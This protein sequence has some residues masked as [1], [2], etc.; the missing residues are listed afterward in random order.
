MRALPNLP[1]FAALRTFEVVGRLQSFRKASEELCISQSAVS[2]HIKTLEDGVRVKLFSRHPR[3][4]AFTPHGKTYW[5]VVREAFGLVEDATLTLRA[6]AG[7]QSVKIS[8]LPSF[9]TGWLVQ[10]LPRFRAAWPLVTVTLDPR[11]ELVDLD[12][13][14]A[15]L[16]IRYGQG[17]WPGVRSEK[18]LAE[19]LSPVASPAL[20]RSG[21]ALQRPDDVLKHTLLFVSR[22]YEWQLWADASGVD[23]SGARTL[24][25]TEYNIVVQAA[26]DGLGLAMGRQLLL[27]DRL[28]SAALVQPL[29][30]DVSPATLG[31]WICRGRRSSP[32]A[33]LLVEW[34]QKEARRP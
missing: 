25:L 23:L 7:P 18:L 30:S 5:E 1:S 3:G 10:R 4:I 13:G 26:V 15:D 34:L 19:R 20:M 6:P 17:D 12:G 27:A 14:E 2:Y 31:Y 24:Q 16:A 33:Q 21:P 9:A 11:L 29:Q 28:R 8:V 22:P 32:Q